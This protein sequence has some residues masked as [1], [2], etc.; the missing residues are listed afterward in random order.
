MRYKKICRAVALLVLVALFAAT[1]VCYTN[2]QSSICMGITVLDDN[3]TAQ[4]I[5]YSHTDLSENI[6]FNKISWAI[7][8]QTVTIYIF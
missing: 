4:Y 7:D 8:T 2:R 3:Q 6:F 5:N 1:T